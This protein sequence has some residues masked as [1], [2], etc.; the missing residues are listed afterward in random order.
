MHL[1]WETKFFKKSNISVSLNLQ[2]TTKG[3]LRYL[4]NQKELEN[5]GNES[6]AENC[7]VCLRPLDGECCVLRCGHRFHQKPCFEQ[8]LQRSV[9]INV[10]CPMKCRLQT[11]KDDVMIATNK[12]RDDG[13]SVIRKIKGSYGTKITRIVGDILCMTDKGEKG[14]VFSQWNDMLDILESALVENNVAIARPSRG[15]RFNESLRSFQSPN[16]PILLLNLKQ[17]AEG[18]TLVHA[19]HVFMVEPVMNNSLDQQAIN[20]IHRIGQ[21][22]R[23]IVWHRRCASRPVASGQAPCSRAT[24]TAV[25]PLSPQALP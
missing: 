9:G 20:R 2:K 5:S 1:Q 22:R 19:S 4:Q 17:G 8:I 7:V 18:L 14:V 11:S 15:S 21:T 10:H 16:C 6:S 24:A 3:T 12:A 13:S 23:T 25:A